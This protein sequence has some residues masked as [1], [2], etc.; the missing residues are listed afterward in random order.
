M[1]GKKSKK[2]WIIGGILLLLGLLIAAYFKGKSAKVSTKV[3]ADSV[4]KRTIYETVSASGRIFPE[5]EVN[6]SSDVSG[7]IVELYVAEG[8]SVKAGQLLA[9][10]DPEALLS[11]V[12][13]GKASVNTSKSQ[14]A[15]AKAQLQSTKAQREQILAQVENVR[16]THERNK[17]LFKDGII[18][19]GEYDQ[20]VSSLKQ[21][22]SN[23]RAADANITSSN[24]NIEG[25][26]YAVTSAQA[27]LKELRTNL[28]RTSIKAPTTG[29]ISKLSVEKGERVVGTAQMTGTQLMRIANLQEMEVQVNVSENDILRVSVGDK[30]D[31]NVDAYLEHVFKGVVTEIA[32]SASNIGTNQSLS[33][34]Q[35]TNFVVKVRIDSDSYTSL[36]KSGR[37]HPL[38][39]GMSASVDIFT[40]QKSD[41]LTIP[42]QAVT[43]R[44]GTDIDKNGKKVLDEVVFV[45]E[46]DTVKKINVRTGIQNSEH[47]VVTDGL[48]EG[49][50]VVQG[51]YSIVSKT[52]KQGDAVSIKKEEEEDK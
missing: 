47:I 17:Q 45:I 11:A 21:A 13:R 35:V 30:V 27:S 6:I 4:T 2:W 52:L 23:L 18:S 5:K 48:Q 26:T 40:D 16:K 31:V 20:S 12:D 46:A 29:V 28:N 8:D 50:Q 24:Q 7:E 44:E 33:T 32:S 49:D 9:K 43:V 39:P 3:E 10:I 42:I 34:D 41:V 15:N 51:P 22:E 38:R 19:A 14:L 25:A 36:M 1:A 37:S